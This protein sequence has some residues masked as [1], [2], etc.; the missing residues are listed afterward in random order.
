MSQGTTDYFIAKYDNDGQYQWSLQDGREL[1]DWSFSLAIDPF[2]N[3]Y[4]TGV[5]HA[6]LPNRASSEDIFIARYGDYAVTGGGLYTV[7]GTVTGTLGTFTLTNNGGDEITIV[8][9]G[10]FTFP[11]GL[12]DGASYSV[13]A[14]GYDG[15]FSCIISGGD[16][17]HGAG[18]IPGANVTNIVV[19]CHGV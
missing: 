11:T 7:G 9:D 14:S 15:G 17:N 19:T 8:E 5:T 10:S 1:E 13:E 16:D 12:P 2:N 18:V 6:L 3:I 4:A